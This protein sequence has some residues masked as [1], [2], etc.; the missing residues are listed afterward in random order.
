MIY[1]VQQGETS[2]RL[3]A[4]MPFLKFQLDRFLVLN[5]L[6]ATQRLAVD[7]KLKLVSN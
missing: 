5:G 1:E 4:R 3:D 7:R 2:C 6:Q